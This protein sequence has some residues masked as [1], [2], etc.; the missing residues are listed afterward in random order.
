[1]DNNK[2]GKLL[3]G[4]KRYRVMG[5]AADYSNDQ[6]DE[7][8]KV[9]ACKT[10]TLYQCDSIDEALAHIKKIHGENIECTYFT[11]ERGEWL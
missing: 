6:K 5:H 2:T 7:F 9:F 10:E 8:E 3:E 4:S 11:I 1:M